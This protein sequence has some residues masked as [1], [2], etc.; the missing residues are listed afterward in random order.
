MPW[1]PFGHT[2][3]ACVLEAGKE[4]GLTLLSTPRCKGGRSNATFSIEGIGDVSADF[5]V[6]SVEAALTEDTTYT[7]TATRG[8]ESI[9][10]SVSIKVREGIVPGW[11]ILDDFDNW[12]AGGL[13]ANTKAGRK[14]FWTDPSPNP[15][16]IIK[17][18]E[19]NQ[20]LSMNEEGEET[21]FTLLQSQENR[22]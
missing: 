14:E 1:K 21:M 8:D 12:E 16:G 9:S 11:F 6:G 17:D 10:G 3:A 18:F 2:D 22:G 4:P 15:A 13:A 19:G 7:V 5:G 20:V